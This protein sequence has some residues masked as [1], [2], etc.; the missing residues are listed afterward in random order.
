MRLSCEFMG[1]SNHEKYP[2]TYHT[3]DF[4]VICQ[5]PKVWYGAMGSYLPTMG[6]PSPS[7][8]GVS[9]GILEAPGAGPTAQLSGI[10]RPTFDI[11]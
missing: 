5:I 8:L 7:A 3:G 9:M 11:V 1:S 4:M 6:P 2:Q 10:C